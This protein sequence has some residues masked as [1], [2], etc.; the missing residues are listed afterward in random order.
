M[1]RVRAYGY[2]KQRASARPR[3][4][5]YNDRNYH[6]IHCSHSAHS[7]LD[8][9]SPFQCSRRHFGGLLRHTRAHVTAVNGSARQKFQ[10]MRGSAKCAV[11]ELDAREH[12]RGDFESTVGRYNVD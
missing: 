4:L 10:C 11:R 6:K 8:E 7:L 9:E 5:C 12:R 2:R 3:S 1:Q